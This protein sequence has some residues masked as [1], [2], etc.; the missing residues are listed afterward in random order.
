MTLLSTLTI[1]SNPAYGS[2]LNDLYVNHC[3]T[4]SDINEHLPHIKRLAS[5][6]SSVAEFGVRDVVSTW[7]LLQGLAESQQPTKSYLGVDLAQ[8][9]VSRF[10]LAQLL[11]T[12]N[13][14]LFQFHEGDDLKFDMDP[15][16]LL[17]I[18]TLHTYCHLT[19]ELEKFSPKANKYI[20]LHDTSPPWG[21]VDD[22]FYHGDYSEYPE[23]YDKTKRGLWP[24]VED[25][26][27]RHPEWVLKERYLNCCGFTV[28]ERVH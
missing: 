3:N 4:Y 8:P 5:E 6:C 21:F 22:Y 27:G 14:I 26:L 9:P 11:A 15:V 1:A 24:A 25:F 2:Q 19:A 18:D 12:E 13:G 17:F 16:D 23:S 7:A 10:H 20:A 28:L